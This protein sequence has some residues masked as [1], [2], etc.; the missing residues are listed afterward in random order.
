MERKE[1]ID[2][3]N[4]KIAETKFPNLNIESNIEYESIEL[5]GK[6]LL[7]GSELFGNFEIND[8]DGNTVLQV[9]SPE[10]MKFVLYSSKHNSQQIRLPKSE[11]EIAAKV[12][13]YESFITSII[14]DIQ[15]DYQSNSLDQTKLNE[16]VTQILNFNNIR[17]Y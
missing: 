2:K 15:T 9:D 8:V 12:K 7:P 13:E 11:S 10:K 4:V 6:V 3:W 14:K 1:F 17:R 16:T 5:P